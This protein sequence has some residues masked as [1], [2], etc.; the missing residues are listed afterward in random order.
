MS[1]RHRPP[2]ARHRRDPR[3]RDQDLLAERAGRSSGSSCSSSCRRRSSSTSSRSRPLPVGDAQVRR[4]VGVG[5]RR[6]PSTSE[7]AWT[8]RPSASSSRRSSVALAGKLAQ[9]RCFRAVADA[10]LGEQVELA[11]RRSATR[12]GGS[13]PS[14]GSSILVDDLRRPRLRLLRRPG[15]LS[16]GR[17]LRRDAR[18]ARRRGAADARARPL[19]RSSSRDAGGG[20][21]AS[22]SSAAILVAPIVA[23]VLTGPHRR[24]SRS[25][26]RRQDTVVGFIAQRRRDDAQQRGHDARPSPRSQPSSTSTCACARR[27]STSAARAAARRRARATARG[28]AAR[29]ARSRRS[30]AAGWQ[31]SGRRAPVAAMSRHAEQ[32]PF[33][34]PPPGWKPGG[35]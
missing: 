20:R 35:E 3:R 16:L 24:R 30:G 12:S 17:V 11:G 33:W 1:A 4:H 31:P 27:G 13:P 26:R 32:P 21:S 29:R 14:S 5:P 8:S 23:G 10:Y 15:H 34:P 2:A 18:P 9:A 6:R 7:H 25:R 28:Y 19:A 22:R